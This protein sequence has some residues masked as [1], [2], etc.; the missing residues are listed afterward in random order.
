MK[1]E[2]YLQTSQA[3]LIIPPRHLQ[4]KSRLNQVNVFRCS[5]GFFLSLE[6]CPLFVVT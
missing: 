2:S 4:Q 5:V 1:M 3:K 6:N